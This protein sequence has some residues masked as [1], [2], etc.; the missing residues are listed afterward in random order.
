MQQR[1]CANS[2]KFALHRPYDT[3]IHRCFVQF[4][5]L[6]QFANCLTAS[7]LGKDLYKY[8]CFLFQEKGIEEWFSK[9]LCFSEC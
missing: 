5:F 7:I 8:K 6:F 9:E 4:Q 2:P 3:S 1:N